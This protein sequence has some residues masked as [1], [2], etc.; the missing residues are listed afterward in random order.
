MRKASISGVLMIGCLVAAAGCGKSSS[1]AGSGGSSGQDGGNGSGGSSSAGGANGYS[2]CAD[3]MLPN[4][5]QAEI[6]T[7]TDCV[8]NA[9]DSDHKTCLGPG[10]KSG[11]FS[12]PCA[13]HGQCTQDC[14][15]DMTCVA[16]CPQSS[17]CQTC[18]ISYA[19][20]ASSCSIPACAGLGGDGGIPGF[21]GGDFDLNGFDL[22]GT[23]LNG[24]PGLDGGFDVPSL[25]LNGLDLGLPGTDAGGTCADLL[26]CCNAATNDGLKNACQ[27]V[28]NSDKSQ[29]DSSCG[30]YLAI[31]KSSVCP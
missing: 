27:T 28:Y 11:T 6:S 14:K 15:C 5:T 31:I 13:A 7:L 1:A 21:D 20:C 12:G 22:G 29:G 25:D 26:A 17:E 16:Q 9:C 24:L 4:C 10:Y 18:E 2:Q 3:S 19:S 30:T 23:D 8:A